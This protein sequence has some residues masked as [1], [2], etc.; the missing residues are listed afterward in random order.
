MLR[1][2]RGYE[3]LVRSRLAWVGLAG[4]RRAIEMLVWASMLSII[5]L[6]PWGCAPEPAGAAFHEHMSSK[7]RP[8]SEHAKPDEPEVNVAIPERRYSEPPIE[9]GEPSYVLEPPRQVEPDDPC[10]IA[11]RVAQESFGPAYRRAG[12]PR[13]LL[14]TAGKDKNALGQVGD[15][16]GVANRQGQDATHLWRTQSV[17]S[18]A[19]VSE[20]IAFFK[21]LAPEVVFVDAELAMKQGRDSEA[22][23]DSL[24]AV[25]ADACDIVI[26]LDLWVIRDMSRESVVRTEARSLGAAGHEAS[27]YTERDLENRREVRVACTARAVR[28][29]DKHTLAVSA[30]DR[31]IPADE[32]ELG[33]DLRRISYCAAADLAN[34]MAEQW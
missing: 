21:W 20:V 6:V 14:I 18:A 8:W 17:D 12:S 23:T 24:S 3:S 25:I 30:P 10:E 29:A 33:R 34:G 2:A 26:I 5:T 7:V 31:T 13:L 16:K 1:Q 27:A 9:R 15:S 11:A 28:V 4:N 19:V 22:G 32:R